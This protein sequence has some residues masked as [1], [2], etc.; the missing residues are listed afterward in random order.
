L[1]NLLFIPCYNDEKSLRKLLIEIGNL[2]QSSFDILIINDGSDQELYFS[3]KNKSLKI[4]NLKNNYGIGFCLKFAIKYALKNNYK[5]FC[6][7]DSDGEHHPKYIKDIF[8][9]LDLNDFILG[10]RKI[11]FKQ[12]YFKIA[13][14]KMINLIIN[15]LFG[16]KID[17]YNCGMM[18]LKVNAMKK[19]K[20]DHFI[21][22][23]EPQ[24][25]L[26]L[27]KNK[28]KYSI[29][30]INQRKR[31]SGNSSINFFGG[32]DFFL[33]TLFFVLNRILN[34]SYD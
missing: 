12:S 24:I 31:F 20:N 27:L 33:I 17:D 29:I 11:L 6:R 3:K 34:N 10:D 28:L 22:Y 5:K 9:M 8:K 18:G 2:Y 1:K 25:I 15:K 4:I 32:L 21:N 13:S 14:K 7:I 19:I 30:K 23:P 26:K 16:L